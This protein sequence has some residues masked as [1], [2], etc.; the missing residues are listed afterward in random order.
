MS[1]IL[2]DVDALPLLFAAQ[3]AAFEK[4]RDPPLAVRR[5][6]LER[7]AAL[8]EEHERE[9]VAAVAADFGARSAQETRLAELFMVRV[10]IRHA[11]RHLSRWMRTR[12]V[13]TPLYLWPGRS[14]VERI[15]ARNRSWTADVRLLG[16]SSASPSLKLNPILLMAR[17]TGG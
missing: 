10:G 3:R 13:P 14:R 2:A 12:R 8:I 15:S 9:I 5:D 17:Q 11:R 1:A 4:E 7:V 16:R 6:R